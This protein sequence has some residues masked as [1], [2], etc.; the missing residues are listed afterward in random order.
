MVNAHMVEFYAGIKKN[1][2]MSFAEKWIELE[3][4]MLT[5][6]RLKKTNIP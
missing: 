3:I 4:I 2:I 6:I 1:E 5:E